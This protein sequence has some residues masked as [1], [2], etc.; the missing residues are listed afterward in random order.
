MKKIKSLSIF[1][2]EIIEA[3]DQKTKEILT[4]PFKKYKYNHEEGTL[5]EIDKFRIY[6]FRE[7]NNTLCSRTEWLSEKGFL[8]LRE[9]EI[10]EINNLIEKEKEKIIKRLKERSLDLRKKYKKEI[11]KE[12]R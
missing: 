6:F 12:L 2:K 9:K 4:K 7:I 11:E 10:V 5:A 8:N 1:R 3:L